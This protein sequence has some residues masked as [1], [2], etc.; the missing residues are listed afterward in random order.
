MAYSRISLAAVA[1]LIISGCGDATLDFRNAELSNGKVYQKGGNEPFTGSLTNFPHTLIR[2]T[3]DLTGILAGL[4]ATLDRMK[5]PDESLR[6]LKLICNG[7]TSEGHLDGEVSCY[8]PGTT[9]LRYQAHYK[10]GAM[11][12]DF[13]TWGKHNNVLSKASFKQDRTNGDVQIYSPNTGTLIQQIQLRAGVIDGLDQRWDD[14][15]GQLTYQA[16]AEKGFYV[17]VAES[18]GPNG[19]KTGEVPYQA[20]RV[21]GVVRAWDAG[22]GQLIE[23]TTFRDGSPDGPSKE[24][25]KNGEVMKV[26]E[27]RDNVF[28][29]AS[30][31]GPSDSTQLDS[32]VSDYIDKFH[33]TNGENVPINNEQLGEWEKWCTQGQHSN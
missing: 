26:G 11:D 3:G 21:N 2:Q 27:Y 22:T 5:R 10:Q 29:T 28:Y 25:S 17:G 20:G 7:R 9:T 12:G 6:F 18:W 32:C 13:T 31:A 8:E 33:S 15:T 23:E 24:W 19:R 30:A 14:K 4:A 16:K 1:A